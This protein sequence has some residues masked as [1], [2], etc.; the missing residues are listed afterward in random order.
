MSWNCV[1]N[2]GEIDILGGKMAHNWGKKW[3]NC[4]FWVGNFNI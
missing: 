2:R 1:V 4:M 3:G